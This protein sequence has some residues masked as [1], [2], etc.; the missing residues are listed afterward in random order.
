M[1]EIGSTKMNAG[2]WSTFNL[3][4]GVWDALRAL[5]PFKDNRNACHRWYQTRFFMV[6]VERQKDAWTFIEQEKLVVSVGPN[7]FGGNEAIHD[8]L[9]EAVAGIASRAAVPPE[10]CYT[11]QDDNKGA[12]THC[13]TVDYVG[14]KIPNGDKR[15]LEMGIH[16]KSSSKYV[17]HMQFQ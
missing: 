5:C 16:L 12:I 4:Y 10:N 11:F 8:L 14:I 15:P 6:D 13:N 17:S 9:L 2:S 1:I 3:W 7:Y